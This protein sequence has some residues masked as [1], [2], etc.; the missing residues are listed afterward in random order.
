MRIHK[1]TVLLIDTHGKNKGVKQVPTHLLRCWG[2]YVVGFIAVILALIVVVGYKAHRLT[3]ESYQAEIAEAFSVKYAINVTGAQRAFQSID[4]SIYRINNFLQE[5][6]IS[7]MQMENVGGGS[8]FFV[9]D[10]NQLATFYENQLLEI[11]AILQYLPLGVPHS[12]RITSPFG[13]RI[14]PI[15]RRGV[16]QHRGIDFGGAIG[17]TI[18]ATANGVVEFAGWSGG[19]GQKII[20]LHENDIRTVYAHLSRKNVVLGQEV[21]T[22]EYIGRLGNSGSTTGPHLHYEIIAP[23]GT[24]LNPAYF[25]SLDI[26]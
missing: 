8:E 18:R 22:G 19:Y 13:P 7:N 1:T 4:E 26:E 14:N 10:I 2:R 5:R 9:T 17:D 23:D 25:F 6:G 24:R 12:G 21:S 16:V 20:L 11:E 3:S 15:T